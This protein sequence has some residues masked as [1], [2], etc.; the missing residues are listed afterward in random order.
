ML[1]T[2][3][4]AC[5]FVAEWCQEKGAYPGEALNTGFAVPD[6]ILRLNARVG[7]LWNSAKRL[8]GPVLQ[9]ATP[10]LGLLGGQDQ[11]LNPN[12]Y[13]PDKNGIVPFVWENQGVWGY[14]FDPDDVDQLF[15]TGD[16]CDGRRGNFETEWR[17]VPAKPED[18]LVCTLLINLCMQSDANWEDTPRPEATHLILWQHPAWS[19][20]NGF[21]INSAKTLIYFSGWRITRR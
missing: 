6:C 10:F 12:G 20:F 4:E 1:K 8:P 11:I 3:D 18:A 5:D 9:Y 7:H 19:D 21:W 2:I 17:R 16:C 15:V 13:S 14:G